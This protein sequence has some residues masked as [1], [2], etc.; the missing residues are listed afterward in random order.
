[1]LIIDLSCTQS[2]KT[3]FSNR[4]Y[5]KMRTKHSLTWMKFTNHIKNA[6]EAFTHMTSGLHFCCRS[7][8]ERMLSGELQL[9]NNLLLTQDMDL[10][11]ELFT[12]RSLCLESFCKIKMDDFS[13][14][15]AD[16]SVAD[17]L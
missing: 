4:S 15:F 11:E 14:Y 2:K 1:M 17:P 9:L 12:Q 16:G 13:V 5:E 10:L 6:A 3:P 7:S 8:P